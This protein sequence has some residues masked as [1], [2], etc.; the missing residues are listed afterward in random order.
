M[1]A[2]FYKSSHKLF[3]NF[4][5]ETSNRAV[6]VVCETVRRQKATPKTVIESRCMSG[7]K[8]YDQRRLET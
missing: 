7:L 6:S 5:K 8:L 2:E 1:M 4:F 3:K